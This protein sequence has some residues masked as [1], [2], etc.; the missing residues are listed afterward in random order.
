MSSPSAKDEPSPPSA[1]PDPLNALSSLRSTKSTT[2]LNQIDRV[3]ASGIGDHISLPQLVVCGDQSAGKSS[4]LERITGIPFPRQDGVCTKFPTEIILRHNKE[5]PSITATVIPAS[6]RGEVDKA[7][8]RAYRRILGDF[9]ELPG[10][11]AEAAELMQI[12]GDGVWFG[13]AFANDVLRI[14]VVGNTGLHLTVVDLPGLIAVASEEQTEKDVALVGSLVDSYLE[15]SRTIILAVVQASNDIANQGIIQRAR[16]FDKDG[17]RTVGIITKPDLINK[18]TEGRIAKLAKNED[19]TKLKLGFFLLQNP[20]PSQIKAGVSREE[21]VRLEKKFFTS[22]PWREQA[23]DH[24][25]VGVDALRLYLH[26]L[27]DRH[28]A[29]E[30]PKVRKEIR[31]VLAQTEA[32]LASL[33]EA[34]PSVEQIRVFLG[35]LGGEFQ[36]LVNAA[37]D[38]NYHWT[39][40]DFFTATEGKKTSTRLRAA[41]HVL[42]G[43]FAS[44]MRYKGQKRQIRESSDDSSESEDDSDVLRVS[45]EEYDAWITEVNVPC[46][47]KI[48]RV[49]IAVRCI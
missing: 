33:G 16:K 26:G 38:G 46:W 32:Q 21:Q 6:G 4:V 43:D 15:S 22:S 5:E 41:L 17:Q 48:R 31:I 40:D 47:P 7:R 13:R 29:K 2:R 30:L 14:E 18:G 27:L 23:L 1:P 35:R 12:R 10:V 25:R 9:E 24:S 44:H 45:Q 8:F 20:S 39:S 37:L 28:I 42:N 36:R 34:R 49:L 3:R 19:T 11:I